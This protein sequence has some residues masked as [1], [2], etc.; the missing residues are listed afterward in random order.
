[1][2][3]AA[4]SLG[5]SAVADEDAG[6]LAAALTSVG[7]KATAPDVSA[8]DMGDSSS[9]AKSGSTP[10]FSV[11]GGGCGFDR[12]SRSRW[13]ASEQRRAALT[14]ILALCCLTLHLFQQQRRRQNLQ[15]CRQMSHSLLHLLL[16]P[17]ILGAYLLL[18]HWVRGWRKHSVKLSATKEPRM[19][20]SRPH[21]AFA[22]TNCLSPEINP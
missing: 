9:P 16:D 15:I 10:A 5:D 22:L 20:T 1:M 2:G 18:V 11:A 19:Q 7:R 8:E 6:L 21:D 17:A 4:A 12:R 14:D 13:R 3:G